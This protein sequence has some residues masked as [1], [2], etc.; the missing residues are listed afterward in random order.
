MAEQ[1]NKVTAIQQKPKN[2]REMNI[3]ILVAAI[4]L[5]YLVVTVF[6]YTTS[7][8]VFV[9]EV[10]RGSI[11]RD[12]SYTG[13]IMRK[14]HVVNAQ[15]SGFVSF[16]QSE[17]AKIRAGSDIYA[18][19]G[20]KLETESGDDGQSVSLNEEQRQNLLNRTQ[21]FYENFNEDKFSTVYSFKND[22]Q[23]I[24]QNAS[25]QNKDA[26]LRELISGAE[27]G[28]SVYQSEQDGIVVMTFDG[29]EGVS[30]EALEPDIFE[31]TGYESR[32]MEDQMNVNQGEPVYKLITDDNW[33]IY[34]QLSEETAAELSDT[35]MV[36]TRI[37]KENETIWAD[38]S[39]V[40][41]GNVSYGCLTYD[42]SMIRYAK[43]RYVNV[44]LILTDQSGL[45]IPKS[46]VV[47]KNFYVV[48]A[49]YLETIGA[50]NEGVLVSTEE[51]AVFQSVDVLPASEDAHVYLNPSQFEEGS[52]LIKP[53]STET[54]VLKETVPLPG[55]YCINK[56]YAVFR[57]VTILC[58]NDDYYIVQ[59]GISYSLSN[60][61]HIVQNA[62]EVEE[63][64][65]IFQ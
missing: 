54:Y 46:S 53:G 47:E 9:Y 4:I 35:A 10:R 25:S 1:K 42:N 57:P 41:K 49:D 36:R 22:I 51:E 40:K 44:E 50:Y 7:K 23:G 12:N 63:E 20:Q 15:E 19:S 3:G 45:K 28:I 39:I 13:F 31:R 34:I 55:V 59:E 48:P 52:V 18:I 5:V 62:S 60:Y 30:E 33:K 2:K 27:S 21:N 32:Y 17:N 64:E 6:M 37:N 38:F 43:E 16:F 56:G 14:E 8:Q 58:E 24:L 26:R 65:V 61:D 11:V 29:Y